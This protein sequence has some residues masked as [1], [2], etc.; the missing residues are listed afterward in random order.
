MCFPRFPAQE[1]T[2]SEVQRTHPGA[3]RGGSAMPIKTISEELVLEISRS[4]PDLK[5][6]NLSN[7]DIRAVENLAP[8]TA[9]ER[10][11]LSGVPTRACASVRD[12]ACMCACVRACGWT[13][14]RA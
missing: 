12:N 5:L 14:G 10:L 3:A 6:L 13:G 1:A 7:N 4:Y 11:N 2:P 8:L 9:L